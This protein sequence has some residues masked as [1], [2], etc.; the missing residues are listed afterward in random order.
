MPLA[1]CLVVAL[2]LSAT[3]CGARMQPIHVAAATG[4]VE[5][6]KGYIAKKGRLDAPFDE[7]S[8]GLE[9]NS[10]LLRGI[11]PLMMAA[12]GGQFEIVKL[13]VEA[14]AN[15]YAEARPR[16][17][18]PD[19]SYRRTA[20]DFAYENAME[21]QRIVDQR[22]ADAAPILEYLWSKSD[23]ARFAARL[24]W[25]ISGACARYCNEKSGGDRRSNPAL[26]LIGIAPDEPRG[27]GISEAACLAPQPLEVLAFLEKH[28]VRFPKNT[29]HCA[30][31]GHHARSQRTLDQRIAIVTFFLEH[32]ADLE[33]LGISRYAT[34]LMGAASAHDTAMVKFLL[35]RGAN[36]N[37]RNSVGY[38]SVISA[39]SSCIHRPAGGTPDAQQQAQL[40]TIEI[41]LQAG[42]KMEHPPQ[43][44]N[45]LMRDCCRQ[46]PRSATQR[47]I[48]QIYGL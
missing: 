30:A 27:R 26:V 32:G 10:S 42:G 3:A 31:F 15:L 18:R 16:D 20:F 21:L 23:G 28:G 39:G 35:S 34:P 25:Q 4:D 7:P 17:E 2:T 43:G 8:R 9:G 44:T 48:C 22:P 12:R 45:W 36:P 38:N 19:W 5:F 33:D 40:E 29:L 14:G 46:D 41:L 11:T 47:Q 13:L 24:P 6:V 1:R 37:T